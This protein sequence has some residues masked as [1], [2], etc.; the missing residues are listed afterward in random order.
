LSQFLS[1]G[2]VGCAKLDKSSLDGI[3]PLRL[4]DYPYLMP[5]G[6]SLVQSG[7]GSEF[8]HLNTREQVEACLLLAKRAG[9]DFLVLDHSAPTSEYQSLE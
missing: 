9:Y 5:S 8:G 1:I 4:D 6:H 3:N 2:L 7:F